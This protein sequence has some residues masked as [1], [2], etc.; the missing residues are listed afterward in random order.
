MKRSVAA[1]LLPL[2]LVVGGC[3]SQVSAPQQ[4]R[5]ELVSELKQIVDASK[6]DGQI[7]TIRSEV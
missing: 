1:V 2:A 4:T 6:P 3:A 7:H 5:E